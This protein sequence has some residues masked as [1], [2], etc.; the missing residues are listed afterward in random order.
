MENSESRV[1]SC[2]WENV[3]GRNMPAQKEQEDPSLEFAGGKIADV[4]E[5]QVSGRA[6]VVR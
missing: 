3:M 5:F 1:E 4:L 6:P 2:C